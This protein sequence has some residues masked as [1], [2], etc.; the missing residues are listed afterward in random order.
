MRRLLLATLPAILL[1]AGV[2]FAV[3]APFGGR[4]WNDAAPTVLFLG[5][6]NTPDLGPA[7]L[8]TVSNG[9]GQEILGLLNRY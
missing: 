1:V 7:A 5:I 8:L 9:S 2:A 3:W 4:R 6:T